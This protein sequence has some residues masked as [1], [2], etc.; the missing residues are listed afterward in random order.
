MLRVHFSPL[1]RRGVST[2][3]SISQLRC[4]CVFPPPPVPPRS[5]GSRYTQLLK[6]PRFCF[7]ALTIVNTTLLAC[8]SADG[9]VERHGG[10]HHR[11]R[12]WRCCQRRV[13]FASAQ[14]IDRRASAVSSLAPWRPGHRRW[15]KVPG[16]S[17]AAAAAA[18]G[19]QR[20]GIF[21]KSC[22]HLSC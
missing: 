2:K 8:A 6:Q 7:S 3:P 17:A 1:K 21:D 12:C 18:F 13:A 14:P 5:R 4:M 19:R 9:A 16:L 20:T 10:R 15:A 11:G 22:G